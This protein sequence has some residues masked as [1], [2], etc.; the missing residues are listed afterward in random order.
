LENDNLLEKKGG[1]RSIKYNLNSNID[2]KEGIARQFI[3]T[4][5]FAK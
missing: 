3:E 1:G 5:Q 4:I 2:S